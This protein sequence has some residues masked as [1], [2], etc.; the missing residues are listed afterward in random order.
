MGVHIAL[1]IFIVMPSFK[2]FYDYAK[3]FLRGVDSVDW[4]HKAKMI[5]VL[6]VMAVYSSFVVLFNAA[7]LTLICGAWGCLIGAFSLVLNLICAVF[8]AKNWRESAY[9]HYKTYALIDYGKMVAE[10]KV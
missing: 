10:K 3:V 7:M 1:L 6:T 4:E 9:R 8:F 2:V 5:K